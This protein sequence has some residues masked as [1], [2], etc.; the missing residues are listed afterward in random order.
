MKALFP[1]QVQYSGCDNG[2]NW[3]WENTTYQ[4]YVSTC[5]SSQLSEKSFCS[6]SM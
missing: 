5:S 6:K 1:T 2:G 4:I 3:L